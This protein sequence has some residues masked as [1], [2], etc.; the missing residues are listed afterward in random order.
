MS[1]RWWRTL[2]LAASFAPAAHAQFTLTTVVG[3]AEQPVPGVYDL[4]AVSSGDAVAARFRLRNTSNAPATLTVLAVA[5]TGF[6][7]ASAPSLPTNLGAQQTADFT[8][9]FHASGTGSY[10]A[11]LRSDGISALLTITVVLGLTYAVETAAGKELLGGAAVDFGV[12][13]LGQTKALH[14]DIDNLTAQALNV[15]AMAV[16]AGDFALSNAAT[17]VLLQP[18]QSAGFDIQFRASAAGPRSGLLTI[19]SRSY[20]LAA[21]GIVPALPKPRLTIDL[22]KNQSAQQGSITITLDAPAKTGG[23]GTLTLDFQPSPAGSSDPSIAFAAGGRTAVFTFEPGDTEG[24]FGNQAM[25]LFQTGTTAGDLTA[26]VQLGE[27]TDRLSVTIV[28]AP[29]ALNAAQ[30]ARSGGS[31]EILVT[32]YDNTRT[33]GPLSFTF[34]DAAGNAV[35]PGPIRLDG[36]AAFSKFFQES[37]VGG[38]FAL[39]ALFPVTGDPSG[40]ASFAAE[41]TNSAG[42][43]TT[44]KTRF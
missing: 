11:A 38:T 3:N 18:G 10:S 43:V 20:V 35:A 12:V 41:F 16:G 29:M 24:R 4:G 1:A 34:F 5:G 9:S 42:T 37:D 7:L 2:A 27:V 22:P 8:V 36:T 21:A 31:I 30:A 23:S 28:P 32:G 13:E 40:V 25:A 17:G 14:F 6:A 44:A 15:P 19:G 33:A 39:R 26:T